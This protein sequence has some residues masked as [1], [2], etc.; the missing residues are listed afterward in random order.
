MS[1]GEK[2][3]DTEQVWINVDN[4]K[5]MSGVGKSWVAVITITL[6]NVVYRYTE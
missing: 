2:I 1:D 3:R 6:L 5:M 4:A